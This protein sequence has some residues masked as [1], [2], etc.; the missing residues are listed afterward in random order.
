MCSLSGHSKCLVVKSCIIKKFY[1]R[2]QSQKRERERK[3]EMGTSCDW[4]SLS[5]SISENEIM[6]NLLFLLPQYIN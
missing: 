6:S 5:A 1:L 4:N 2:W 3:K